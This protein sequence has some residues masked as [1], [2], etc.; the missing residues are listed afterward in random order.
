MS[1]LD[2]P[3]LATSPARAT[4]E[5][6]SNED[7]DRAT[8]AQRE[9]DK[10]KERAEDIVAHEFLYSLDLAECDPNPSAGDVVID[11]LQQDEAWLSADEIHALVTYALDHIDLKAVERKAAKIIAH[12]PQRRANVPA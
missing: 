7:V 12:L 8:K 3:G 9:L 11:H 10:R 6:P 5:S 1:Q 4:E 2:L